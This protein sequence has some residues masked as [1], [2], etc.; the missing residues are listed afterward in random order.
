M[1]MGCVINTTHTQRDGRRVTDGH[2]RSGEHCLGAPHFP[3]AQ[4][5]HTAT[6]NPQHLRPTAKTTEKSSKKCIFL[7]SEGVF[8]CQTRTNETHTASFFWGPHKF[9]KKFFFFLVYPSVPVHKIFFDRIHS[10]TNVCYLGKTE[11]NKE[12]RQ[13]QPIFSSKKNQKLFFLFYYFCLLL[14]AGGALMDDDGDDDDEKFCR[15]SVGQPGI[16]LRGTLWHS[17]DTISFTQRH[18]FDNRQTDTT[19]LM[20]LK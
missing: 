5:S 8:G 13:R 9:P 1:T 4:Y 20:K 18:T 10:D 11:K 12:K 19:Y 3:Y 14:A 15:T 7:L 6:M 17:R 2:G 16:N